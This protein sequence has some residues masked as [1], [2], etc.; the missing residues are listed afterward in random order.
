MS[1]LRR[2]QVSYFIGLFFEI[3]YE[4]HKTIQPRF[5]RITQLLHIFLN[6]KLENGRSINSEFS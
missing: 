3:F 5:I 2:Q 1:N 6:P 4:N